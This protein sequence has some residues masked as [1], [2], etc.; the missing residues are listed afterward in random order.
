MWSSYTVS[1]IVNVCK[2]RL[3]ENVDL[4]AVYCVHFSDIFHVINTKQYNFILGRS[5]RIITSYTAFLFLLWDFL[6]R[7]I[8]KQI[9]NKCEMSTVMRL[10]QLWEI[11]LLWNIFFSLKDVFPTIQLIISSLWKWLWLSFIL[12]FLWG[13]TLIMYISPI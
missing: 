4:G 3:N 11:K 2:K 9:S 6:H 12:N 8:E 5:T 13:W 1:V 7:E 10:M